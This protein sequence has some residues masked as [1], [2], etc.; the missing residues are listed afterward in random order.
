MYVF[1]FVCVCV[2]LLVIKYDPLHRC[3]TLPLHK[4]T[5]GACAYGFG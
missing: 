1:V 3:S 5:R 4:M 2:R